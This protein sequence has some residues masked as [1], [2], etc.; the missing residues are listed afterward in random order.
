M[1]KTSLSSS[2]WEDRLISYANKTFTFHRGQRPPSGS[3]IAK[4]I[5]SIEKCPA[6]LSLGGKDLFKRK[7]ICQCGY[8]DR[9]VIFSELFFNIIHLSHNY[10]CT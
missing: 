6:H 7:I 1:P 2:E 3:S 9:K 5:L 4:K 8:H 10:A